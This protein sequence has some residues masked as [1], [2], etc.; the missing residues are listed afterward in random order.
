[1]IRRQTGRHAPEHPPEHPVRDVY[2]R[3]AFGLPIV[4][5]FKD[6]NK[7]E[8]MQQLL[9]PEDGDRMAS[10][11]IL[12]PYWDGQRWYPSA[13]LIPGWEQALEVVAQCSPGTDH[14]AWPSKSNPAERAQRAADIKPMANRGDDPLS[15]FM[16]YFQED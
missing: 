3:A 7:G 6:E 10:Q 9:V 2:P 1:M 5:H 13:L 12:R 14:R 4:F 16:T 11:L 15:A 8:P